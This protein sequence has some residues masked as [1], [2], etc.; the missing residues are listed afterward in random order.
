LCKDEDDIH[1]TRII[2][3]ASAEPNSELIERY[4]V[5]NLKPKRELSSIRKD[6]VLQA[7]ELIR[8]Y[9]K[10]LLRNNLTLVHFSGEIDKP[11]F[12]YFLCTEVKEN[13]YPWHSSQVDW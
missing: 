2:H 13:E 4:R 5:L 6:F 9:T 12:D 8:V 1:Y 7:Q 3:S 11:Q 10:P